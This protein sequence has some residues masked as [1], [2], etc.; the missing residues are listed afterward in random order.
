[1]TNTNFQR[2]KS[3]N[4]LS[5][6]TADS[7]PWYSDISTFT[8]H[9]GAFFYLK[10][11]QRI[12]YP[13]KSLFKINKHKSQLLIIRSELFCRSSQNKHSFKNPTPNINPYC[14]LLI[15]TN[16]RNCPF[17]TFSYNLKALTILLP[18]KNSDWGIQSLLRLVPTNSTSIPVA[19]YSQTRYHWI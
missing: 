11:K 12:W 2:K 13:I 19:T 10:A 7:Q 3:D 8:K 6:E 9:S 16:L 18:C 17:K 4:S 1:M 5:T 14:I 15:S